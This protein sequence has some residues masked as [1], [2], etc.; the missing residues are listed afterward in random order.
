MDMHAKL[1]RD[2]KVYVEEK[3]ADQITVHLSAFERSQA[4]KG[5]SV[6]RD[7]LGIKDKVAQLW[8]MRDHVDFLKRFC[9]KLPT[10][11]N[12]NKLQSEVEAMDRR[13]A[14]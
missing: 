14:Q 11:T 13:L 4:V 6:Q 5:E 7:I 12:L 3:I 8:E 9:V 1:T 2:L 10:Q